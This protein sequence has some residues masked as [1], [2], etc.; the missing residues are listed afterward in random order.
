VPIERAVFIKAAAAAIL[1]KAPA[2]VALTGGLD[3]WADPATSAARIRVL[4]SA[5][6]RGEMPQRADG[7]IFTFAGRRWRGTPSIVALPGNASGV[8]ATLDIEDYLY[9]VLPIEASPGWPPGA[10]GAHAIVSRTFAL[11]R[12]TLSRPYDV[13]MTQSDQR[14]GGIDA[15]YPATNAAVDATRGDILTFA[16]GTASVFFA[17]CCGGH[18]AD[19]AQ[20]WGHAT[21]P[22]LRGV[23][24]P[25][26]TAAPDYRWERRLA[27]DRVQ[28]ALAAHITGEITGFALGPPDSG[29]RPLS[30]DIESGPERSTLSTIAFRALLGADIVRSTWLLGLAL[31][32]NAV[33]ISGAGRGHGVGLCQWG[34][35]AMGAAGSEPGEILAFYFP[36]TRIGTVNSG[37][38]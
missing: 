26:C 20:I 23:A 34:A 33:V 24:D 36:G 2:A 32:P 18:T 31:E 19:A 13:V 29:G 15:E 9:G 30:L 14:F 3:I 12:R 17:A 35:R 27:R 22:Y 16:G 37:E 10:L 38:E 7:G 25:Y 6:R 21:L 11:G 28:A 4:V 5:D 1:T 8:V